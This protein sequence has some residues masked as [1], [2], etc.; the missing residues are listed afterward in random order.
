MLRGMKTDADL[1]I[2][3]ELLAPQMNERMRRE[4]AA[5]E[6]LA[7]G[8]GGNAIVARATGVAPSTIVRGIRELLER[9]SGGVPPLARSRVRRPGAGRKKETDKDPTLL[10]DLESMVQPLSRGDPESPL[11]WICK[12]LR[13]LAHELTAKG[14]SVGRDTVA[15]LLKSLGFSLQANRKVLE[16]SHHA[17]RDAQFIYINE[18]IAAQQSTGNPALSVDTK[19]KELV[20]EYKNAGRE[21]RPKG[22]PV[23]VDTHDFMGEL[24]RASPYGVYDIG[25]NVGWVNVGITADTSEFAVESLRRWWNFLGKQRYPNATELLVTADCG[26]SNGYRVRLWKLQLQG[27]ADELGIAIT[28]CHLPPGTS[29]WNKIEHRLFSFIT[30]NWRGKPLTD[31]Q[32]I[33]NLIGA[34]KN[35]KGLKVYCTLDENTYEKGRKVSDADMAGMN[36]HR[37]EFHGEWNYTIR[38]RHWMVATS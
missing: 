30:L 32:T 19:K 1:R 31:Y 2:Q 9:T 21:W 24:G 12:S 22:E 4:W 25:A 29:K 15:S 17:D 23:K 36:L 3:Y 13:N 27:L 14:H 28:V 5:T 7:L 10:A 33:I 37:H 8:R 6:A 35:S 20:G 11:L 34:T 26:G 18:R 38:P 16:G